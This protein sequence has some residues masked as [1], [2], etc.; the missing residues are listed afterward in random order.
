MN[1]NS[2][3]K[4]INIYLCTIFSSLKKN[5]MSGYCAIVNK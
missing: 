4:K 3:E 1:T 2:T 5:T